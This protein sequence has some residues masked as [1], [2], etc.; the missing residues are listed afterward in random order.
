MLKDYKTRVERRTNYNYYANETKSNLYASAAAASF[1]MTPVT[2]F[3]SMY[4]LMF[5]ISDQDEE[6]LVSN[7]VLMVHPRTAT[8][9]SLGWFY[10]KYSFMYNRLSKY[11]DSL[12]VSLTPTLKLGYVQ[13]DTNKRKT[14]YHQYFR[15]NSRL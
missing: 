3:M 7:L 12:N 11:F 8:I 14:D 10:E 2:T 6:R 15:A 4:N 1:Y 9:K 13:G 5:D